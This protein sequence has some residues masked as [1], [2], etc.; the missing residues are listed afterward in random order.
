MY[1]SREIEFAEGTKEIMSLVD[2]KAALGISVPAQDATLSALIDEASRLFETY[3]ASI[4]AKRTV[5]ERHHLEEGGSNFVLR[6]CPA[7]TL[8]SVTI[9]GA[10]QTVGA[11]RLNKL[12]GMVRKVDS[13]LFGV[14]EHVIVYDAGYDSIPPA[15]KRA[16]VD[17]VSYLLNKEDAA[18][19]GALRS[20][21]VDDVGEREYLALNERLSYSNGVRLPTRFAL[22]LA[23]YRRSYVA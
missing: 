12:H 19:N 15:V 14:G 18:E 5:T 4:F 1:G 17:Y 23:P 16:F 11:F 9:A 3:C 8:T 22:A 6:Y 7:I 10:S 21:S 2:V 20:E 13:S